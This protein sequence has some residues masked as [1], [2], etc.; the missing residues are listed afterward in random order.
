MKKFLNKFSIFIGGLVKATLIFLVILL[1]LPFVYFTWRAGQPMSMPEYS[2]RSYYELLSEREAEYSNLAEKYQASHPTI[3][4]KNRMCFT[5]ETLISVVYTLPW[6]GYCA[7][8]GMVPSLKEKIGPNALR[9]GCL[10]HPNSQ[11]LSFP[12]N[13]WK[14]YEKMVYQIYVDRPHDAVPYCRIA[15]H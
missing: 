7:F 6:A 8:A 2:G 15:I 1:V 12:E 9:A 14:T 4:V 11:L 5:N 3:D 13:W 10:S